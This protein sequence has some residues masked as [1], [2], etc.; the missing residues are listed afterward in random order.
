MIL[1]QVCP[2]QTWEESKKSPGRPHP[3][4]DGTISPSGWTGCFFLQTSTRTTL[5]QL[6]RSM[7]G[8]C[9][10]VGGGDGRIGSNVN[11]KIALEGDDQMFGEKRLL[12]DVGLFSGC[13]RTSIPSSTCSFLISLLLCI[14][15]SFS[16]CT[17]LLVTSPPGPEALLKNIMEQTQNQRHKW[18]WPNENTRSPTNRY[19]K[20]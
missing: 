11:M 17:L 3:P 20:K 8:S 13:C 2:I 1:G 9:A 16:F 5:E 15:V 19:V 4:K 10:S 7:L 12:R 14:L 6:P 18:D